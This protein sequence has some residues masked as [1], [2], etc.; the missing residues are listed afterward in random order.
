MGMGGDRWTLS[1]KLKYKEASRFCNNGYR[2]ILWNDSSSL[3]KTDLRKKLIFV[4][5]QFRDPHKI[6]SK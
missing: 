2:I 3:Q 4:L 1:A 6:S 5:S